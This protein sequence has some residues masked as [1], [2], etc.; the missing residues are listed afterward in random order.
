LL[1]EANR[2]DRRKAEGR[3]QKAE[4]LRKIF[5]Q[6]FSPLHSATW[7]Q[8][9]KFIRG[10]DSNI[11]IEM[12]STRYNT[13]LLETPEFIY[14]VSLLPSAFVLLPSHKAVFFLDAAHFVHQPYLGFLWCSL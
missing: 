3:G 14:G 4:G 7:F 2:G 13:S 8:A 5:Y 9:P 10:N 1:E 6:K 11:C 12:R